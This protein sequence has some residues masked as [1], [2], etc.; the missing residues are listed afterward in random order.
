MPDLLSS[1]SSLHSLSCNWT[2]F[3]S[4]NATSS[5]S[6][7]ACKVM[8]TVLERAVNPSCNC[9]EQTAGLVESVKRLRRNICHQTGTIGGVMYFGAC[10]MKAF[11]TVW[12]CTRDAV[13][14]INIQLMLMVVCVCSVGFWCVCWGTF[15]PSIHRQFVS[16]LLKPGRGLWNSWS[17]SMIDKR[18]G[19]NFIS[20]WMK[21]KAPQCWASVLRLPVVKC[22]RRTCPG[23]QL[24]ESR[25]QEGGQD[26]N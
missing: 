20:P 2:W 18:G 3:P 5:H 8:M 16:R 14:C 12:L 22:G 21:T 4:R 26:P 23:P 15:F 13:L 7:K 17:P 25:C 1:M 11:V 19:E 9:S 10:V 6:F 24:G